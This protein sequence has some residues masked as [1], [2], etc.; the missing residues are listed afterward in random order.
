MIP[1]A[2]KV[3]SDYL[4]E[5]DA[6]AA[7]VGRRVVGKTPGDETGG[8]DQPWVRVTQLDATAV[9]GSRHDHLVEF[10]FQFD[11]YA[12]A[13]GGQ[14]EA[15]LLARTLRQALVEMPDASLDD[16]AV[17]TGVDIRGMARI[18]DEEIDEPA[19][20]RFVLSVAIWMHS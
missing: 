14:P 5:N 4:R 12:G 17:A 7:I 11:A 13:D 9:G 16:G 20:E 3:V 1:Y 6:L 10:Y 2:E 19:R 18:P 8:T 15:N